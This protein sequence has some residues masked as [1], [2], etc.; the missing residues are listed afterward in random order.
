MNGRNSLKEQ[1]KQSRVSNTIRYRLIVVDIISVALP[2]IKQTYEMKT[3]GM[4][5]AGTDTI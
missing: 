4:V 1:V 3:N 2:A 5:K